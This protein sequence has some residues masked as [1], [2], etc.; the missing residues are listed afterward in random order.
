MPRL[1]EQT[2]TRQ[3]IAARAG[4][5]SQ[6]AGVRLV[7]LGDGVERGVRMLEFRTGSGLRFSVLVDRA[8]DIAEVEHKGRA[9]GWHSPTGFRHP[10]LHETEAE[11]GFAW[12][13]SFSGFLVTCGLDHILA[14]EQVS[15]E[16]YNYPGRKTVTHALHGRISTIPARL[17]GYGESWDGNRCTLW[18][19]AVIVQATVFGENLH[20]HRRIEAEVGGDEIRLTDRVVNAGFL[21]TPHMMFYH[22]NIGHPVLDEGARFLAPIREV[23]WASHD[24]DKYE[25]QGSGY[26]RAPAPINGFIEQVWQHEMASNA[27][28]EVPLA[29]VNDRLGLGIEIVTRKDQMPCVYQWQYFQSGAYVMGIEPSTHHVLGNNAARNR[30]EMIWLSPQEERSYHTRFRVL[31]GDAAIASTEAAIRAIAIQPESDFPI[32]SGQFPPLRAAPVNPKTKD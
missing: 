15:I 28:G 10:G 4:S 6:F 24:G 18:A 5:L 20:L 11:G 8:M 23:I 9:I 22:V 13:R 16:S 2:L 30:G 3:D 32:P 7:I 27:A 12:T 29:L 25:A 19:E 26:Q 17:T 31:D 21:T 1:Y 14:P